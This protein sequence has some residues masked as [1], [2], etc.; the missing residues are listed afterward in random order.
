MNK[1][2][3]ALIAVVLAGTTFSAVAQ[4]EAVKDYQKYIDRMMDDSTMQM[5]D[6]NDDGVI[7]RSEFKNFYN[8]IFD[9]MDENKDDKILE[10]EMETAHQSDG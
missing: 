9:M 2:M 5:L 7:T 6:A 10:D 1:L 8:E 3:S 4:Q